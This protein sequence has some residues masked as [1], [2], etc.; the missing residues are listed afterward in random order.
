[1]SGCDLPKPPG[2][3]CLTLDKTQRALRR[4]AWRAR[5]PDR[6]GDVSEVLAE[7]LGLLEQVREENRKMRAAYY[8]MR[9]R[10]REVEKHEV[11]T[12]G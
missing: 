12:N 5:N 8:N 4:L 3:T 11:V 9:E 6:A 10:L 7:G 1:M 2:H